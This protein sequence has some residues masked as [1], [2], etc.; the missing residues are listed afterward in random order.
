LVGVVAV[1][2]VV[3][4]ELVLVGVVLL[5]EVLV[6]VEVEVLLDDEEVGVEAVE[7]VWWRQSLRARSAIVRAP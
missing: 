5:V 1:L 7:E 4:D 3:D 2:E 6:D